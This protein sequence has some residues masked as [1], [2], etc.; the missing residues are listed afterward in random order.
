LISFASRIAFLRGPVRFA[1]RAGSLRF[2]GRSLCFA[3]RFAPTSGNRPSA[4]S[5]RPTP[6]VRP[7][8]GPPRR[9]P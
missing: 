6:R 2:A 5:T 3:G 7:G 8:A 9:G 1:S 4:L